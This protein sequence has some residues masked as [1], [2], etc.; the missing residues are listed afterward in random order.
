MK[1]VMMVG[2][3]ALAMA[4]SYG[5][6][7]VFAQDAKAPESVGVTIT[8][9]NFGLLS[10]LAKSEAASANG[11]LAQMNALKVKE[12]KSADGN[13]IAEL[14]GK[15]VFYLPTKAADSLLS[16]EAYRGKT[17]TI[18]GKLF[19]AENALLVEEVQSEDGDAGG[20]SW[21]SLPVGKKSQ[22]QVL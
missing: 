18:I 7:G 11:A 4:I 10:T 22:L 14:A 9:T 13:A 8:G 17:V 21:D 5:V 1:K 16:G 12:A 19:K 2:L 15:T 3:L 6:S 20:D